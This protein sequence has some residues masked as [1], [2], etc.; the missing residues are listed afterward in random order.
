M[1]NDQS[2]INNFHL[3]FPQNHL[4]EEILIGNILI[5]SKL[6][7]NIISKIRIQ[8]FFLECHQIIYMHLIAIH[9]F[10]KLH[11]IQ[12]L[13]ELAKNQILIKIGGINKIIELMKQSQIFTPNIN[14]YIYLE[15]LINVINAEYSRRLMMQYGYNIIQLASTKKLSS[16][17]LNNKASYYLELTN[18]KIDQDNKNNLISNF[19]LEL[20]PATNIDKKNKKKRLFFKSGFKELDSLI[21]GLTSGNLIIIAGRPGIG[22][23]S[24][25]INIIGNILKKYNCNS[26]IFSLEM[27]SKQILEKIISSITK[28]PIANL[29]LNQINKTQWEI[30]KN[31]CNQLLQK[32]IHINDTSNISIEYIEYNI[33]IIK[34]KKETINILTIDYLQLLQSHYAYENNRVQQLSYITRK[35]KLLSQQLGIPFIVLSQLNRGIENRVNKKPLLSD[36]RESGCI[37]LNQCINVKILES[38]HIYTLY[39]YMHIMHIEKILWI[40]KISNTKRKKQEL[41]HD[42]KN[43]CLILKHEYIFQNIIKENTKLN[44]VKTTHNHQYFCRNT[45]I[46]QSDCSENSTIETSQSKHRTNLYIVQIIAFQYKKTYDININSFFYFKCNNIILHNSI[47]QDADIVIMLHEQSKEEY[48][49]TE[50]KIIDI[51]LCKNRNGPTGSFQLMFSSKSTNFNNIDNKKEEK[52][53]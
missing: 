31:I 27:S 21:G 32:K 53:I 36:L 22:K 17:A 30:V 14:T 1:H 42:I 50:N 43:I 41:L 11:P 13:D 47:E 8:S 4:A 2:I 40:N 19:L 24:F 10:N 18:K 38:A 48:K 46:Q 9:Q 23:T 28:I 6:L 3:L 44:Q 51:T 16:N 45:W 5:N 15:E 7:I 37:Y 29:T 25:V 20:N 49:N 33:K 34:Q 12:L 39:Q 52:L 26:F 35:L